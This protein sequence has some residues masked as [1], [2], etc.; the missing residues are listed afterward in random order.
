MEKSAFHTQ[1]NTHTHNWI[2]VV[3]VHDK[4]THK[5]EKTQKT[6]LEEG[7]VNMCELSMQTCA[8]CWYANRYNEFQWL[9]KS[10][11]DSILPTERKLCGQII[12]KHR[13]KII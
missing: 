1:R 11:R 12:K 7:K 2:T 3:R 8:K 10:E 9:R 13:K 6:H 4:I 5:T